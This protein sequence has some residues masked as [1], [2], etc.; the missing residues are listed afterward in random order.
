MISF[1]FRS[2]HATMAKTD[3]FQ[4]GIDDGDFHCDT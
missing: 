4:S 2:I 1:M 3:L